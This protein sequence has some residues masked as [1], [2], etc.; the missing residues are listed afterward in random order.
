VPTLME[1]GLA[2]RGAM[3]WFGIAAP[4]GT[5]PEVQARIAASLEQA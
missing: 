4:A 3:S 1:V 2:E 5:P